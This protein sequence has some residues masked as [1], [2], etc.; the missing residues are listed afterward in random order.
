MIA[1]LLLRML[2]AWFPPVLLA[3]IIFLSSSLAP[4]SPLPAPGYSDKGIHLVIYAL[5]ALFLA[6]A[7]SLTRER[8]TF[9]FI[10]V[11][12]FSIASFYGISDEFHQMFVPGRTA[13]GMD[14]LFD[15]IGAGIGVL[16]FFSL[17]R[18]ESSRGNA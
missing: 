6:R 7:L 2:V 8:M 12:S 16:I 9:Q 3:V 10:A 15:W 17:Y 5:L 18:R 14:L 1:G 13:E 4:F 11:L